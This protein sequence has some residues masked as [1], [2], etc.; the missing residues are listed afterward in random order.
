MSILGRL[1][2]LALVSLSM[3]IIFFSGNNEGADY[4]RKT[5]FEQTP[6]M[7]VVFEK[8]SEKKAVLSSFLTEE[9]EPRPYTK[10]IVLH[11][12]GAND[13][14]S[15]NSTTNDK[16][17]N[18]LILTDGTIKV[19][20]PDE[21]VAQH[22]GESIW[23]GETQLEYYSVGIEIVGYPDRDLTLE[24]YLSLG[25]LVKHY[26]LKYGIPDENVLSHAAVAYRMT[27]DSPYFGHRGRKIDG[28]N[29]EMGRIG[30]FKRPECDPDV[31]SGLIA[32][33]ES[34]EKILYPL[35]HLG[36]EMEKKKSYLKF[37]SVSKR[38]PKL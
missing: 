24:Q 22:A 3:G 20:V 4:K 13:E 35:Q 9:K 19:I 25:C 26:Q 11:T 5:I 8:K 10:Y 17:T 6:V 37:A 7:E 12:T 34:L 27:K 30:V 2:K 16:S 33:S 32:P 36:R 38:R 31:L 29:I 18:D 1:E 21:F 23:N 14:S 28:I 15:F